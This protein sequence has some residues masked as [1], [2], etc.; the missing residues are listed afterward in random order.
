MVRYYSRAGGFQTLGP[1]TKGRSPYT[2]AP[3]QADPDLTLVDEFGGLSSRARLAI[4]A[5]ASVLAMTAGIVLAH[6][7]GAGMWPFFVGEDSPQGWMG[8]WDHVRCVVGTCALGDG[9]E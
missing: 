2:G 9:D 3:V 1:R 4:A 7:S 5:I 6:L 8:L